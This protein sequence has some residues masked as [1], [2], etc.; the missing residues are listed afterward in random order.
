MK[1]ILITGSSGFIGRHLSET[2]AKNKKNFIYCID[3]KKSN[4]YNNYENLKFIN[5]NLKDRISFPKVDI[6]FHLAAFN[7]TKFFYLKPFEVIQDNIIPTYN[8]LNY[9]KKNKPSLFIYAG[10]P[11]STAG[12][13][14]YFK[15]KIPTDE[16]SPLVIE[17]PLNL[18][19]SYAG[20]KGLGEQFV[21]SS[22]LNFIIL[23]YNNVYGKYQKDHFIPDFIKRVK[24]NK[25][26]LYGYKNTRTMIHV[27]DAVSASIKVATNKKC[28]NQIFNIGGDKEMSILSVAKKIMK[29]MNKKNKIKL[30]PA[31]KGSALRRLPD[32]SKIRKFIAFKPKISIDDGIDLILKNK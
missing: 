2:L 19:W 28:I 5:S 13:T 4:F 17:D 6:V 21:I 32:I 23:R 25:Y 12:A 27:K 24:K 16:K 31:P 15:Y 8:L 20:S 1:K 7:G 3:K 18:R 29:A 10:S 30:M 14:D 11:E 9:Y 22:G 26:E